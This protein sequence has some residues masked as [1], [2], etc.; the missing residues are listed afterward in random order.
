MSERPAKRTKIDTDESGDSAPFSS[1][2]VLLLKWDDSDRCCIVKPEAVDAESSSVAR[3]TLFVVQQSF[4]KECIAY[5]LPRE[6]TPVLSTSPT[7]I[8]MDSESMTP[9]KLATINISSTSALSPL[10]QLHADDW[11]IE[12]RYAHTKEEDVWILGE[13]SIKLVDFGIQIDR[14][15]MLP[16]K[17]WKYV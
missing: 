17:R 11:I 14:K 9:T 3:Y 13:D 12:D 2:K 7:D 4:V 5:S 10:R 8:D 16:V 6:S 1:P 15:R